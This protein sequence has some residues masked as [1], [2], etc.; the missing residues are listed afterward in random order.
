LLFDFRTL[1]MQ[2]RY[3]FKPISL[4]SVIEEL[5][6]SEGAKFD[7]LG[8]RVKLELNPELP[9]ILADAGKVKQVLLNLCKNAEEAMPKGGT[10]AVRAYPSSGG[11]NLELADTGVGLPQDFDLERPF[12]TTK[13][14]GTG[15]GLVIVRQ[16]VARHQGVLSYRSEPEGGTTFTVSFPATPEPH[17]LSQPL[18]MQDA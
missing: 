5:C 3:N 4:T 9:Q 13:P 7:A 15:L 6:A 16:I 14:T 11:V 18:A 1:S 17:R 8:I 12:K 10:L 2:E